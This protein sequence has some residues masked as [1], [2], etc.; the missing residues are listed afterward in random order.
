MLLVSR[1]GYRYVD[2][3]CIVQDSDVSWQHNTHDMHPIYSNT[4]FTICAADGKGA[5]TDLLALGP[6]AW[7]GAAAAAKEA[8]EDAE[9]DAAAPD[10]ETLVGECN[11][12]VCLMATQLLESVVNDL[13]WKSRAW[14]FQERV[15]LRRCLIFANGYVYFQCHTMG[16]SQDIPDRSSS[17]SLD[18]TNLPLRMLRE[19]EPRRFWFYRK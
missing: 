19:F 10:S 13:E 15:L 3:L 9:A 8:D 5:N 1:L 6:V 18:R 2:A 11:P 12:G 7:L 17:W 4:L 14:T 16:I